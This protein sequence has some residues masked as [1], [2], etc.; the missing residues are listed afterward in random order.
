MRL[1]IAANRAPYVVKKKRNIVNVERSPGGLVSAL[2]PIMR[3]RKG[4]WVCTCMEDNYYDVEF[5]YEIRSI[6]LTNQEN[7][8]YY[9]GFGNT[10]IWP[11]F[12]YLPVRYLSNEK[13]WEFYVKVNKKFSNQI[14]SFVKPDDIIWIQDYHLMLV[15]NMLRKAGVTNKIGFFM[16]IPFP[17]YEVF[18]I[19]PKRKSLLEGLLGADVIG[20]HTES[21]QKHFL[22]CVRKKIN[23]ADVDM[24]DN[25]IYYNNRMIDVPAHPISIDYSLID[26]TARK[27]NVRYKVK[28]LRNQFNVDI[29]GLGVDRLDYT[30]G[31]F[32]RLN[33]IEYFLDTHPEYHKNFLFVQIAV[34]SRTKVIEYQ[35]IKREVD[36]AVGRIN[37]KF[38]KDGWSPISY[39]YNSVNFEELVAYY[40]CA[41]FALITSLRDGLNLVTKEYIASRINNDGML[42]LSEFIGASEEIDTGNFINPFD[43]RSISN[44]ILRAIKASNEEKQRI[45]TNLRQHVSENNVYKWVDNFLCRL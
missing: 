13:D 19:T 5:P 3:K 9:E 21:Y 42:I 28:K 24:I 1:V 44:G 12:H 23:V 38:S 29:V 34:P 39:I 40:S 25:H 16:H 4:I 6:K 27:P 33:G 11:L 30:K 15:P 32:E 41:D 18:R 8:H 10:Q 37:G 14:F 31:I 43:V 45:M 36:E 20:F 22:E 2:D 26:E 17:N 7:H 35:K